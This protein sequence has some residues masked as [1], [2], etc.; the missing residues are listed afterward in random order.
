VV[1]PVLREE[2]CGLSTWS[3]FAAVNIRVG[4][5]YHIEAMPPE[6]GLRA[7]SYVMC[8][9]VRSVSRERLSKRLGSV[10]RRILLLAEDSLRV[11]IGL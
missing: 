7:K 1:I 8:D 5:P 9:D 10:S 4:I 6:G 11:L 3:P 2:G